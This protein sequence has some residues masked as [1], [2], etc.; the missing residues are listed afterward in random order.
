MN[1]RHVPA[2]LAYSGKVAVVKMV[3]GRGNSRW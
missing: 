1:T 3:S 2:A